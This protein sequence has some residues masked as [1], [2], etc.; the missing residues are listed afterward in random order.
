MPP[1]PISRF[2]AG[3]ALAFSAALP[4]HAGVSL[5]EV[6]VIDRASGRVLPVHRHDGRLWVEGVPGARYAIRVY[7]KSHGRL[8]AVMSVDG[9][10]VVSGETANTGQS[11]YV[12]SP[13]ERYDI[14]GWRR[15]AAQ[16]AAFEFTSLADSY[17][18]RTGRPEH[19]GVIGVALFRERA[20]PPPVIAPPVSPAPFGRRDGASGND[21]ASS[22][23]GASGRAEAGP[24]ASAPAPSA[25]AAES[26]MEARRATPQAGA[27]DMQATQP[28]PTAKL[29]TGHG[30]RETSRVAFTEF[31]RAQAAPDEVIA[32]HYDSRENLVA[33]GVIRP[34]IHPVPRPFP[35]QPQ[36][37]FV[38]DP[39]RRW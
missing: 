7:N 39:P 25:P 9:V 5:A 19:V 12:L 31:Q 17:A 6:S 22:G 23:A 1:R 14:A 15:S 20:A 13:W 30:Q 29:G 38:P 35:S 21:S 18:A 34:A 11:G 10:N 26:A 36:L 27:A 32:I 28:A 3:L 37:G 33:L 8:L 16:I 4:A 24:T 2:V